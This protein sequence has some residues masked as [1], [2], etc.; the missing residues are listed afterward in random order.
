M[1]ILDSLSE[2][3]AVAGFLLIGVAACGR[4]VAEMMRARIVSK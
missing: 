3:I 2:I 1:L 4:G